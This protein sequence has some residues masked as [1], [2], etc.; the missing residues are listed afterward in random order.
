MAKKA[1]G[2]TVSNVNPDDIISC[3]SE[4]SS[5]EADAA[6]LGQRKAS[7]FAR[8]EKLGVD[9]KSIKRAIQLAAKDPAEVAAQHQR[10]T[11]YLVILEI[12]SFG[13]DGQGDFSAGLT[14]APTKKPSASGAKQLAKAKVYTDGYNS[15]LAGGSKETC[16]FNP[17]TEQ[18]VWW[19]EAY[20]DGYADRLARKPDADK[21]KVA[22]LSKKRKEPKPQD[23]VP[24]PAEPSLVH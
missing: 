4:I 21:S 3:F 13:P 12:T 18:H 14:V 19:L 16:R 17:G 2:S 1:K 7:T 22:S 11:E 20:S 9:R 5:I 6:R 15:G 10:D 23:A 8:Y 24:Q